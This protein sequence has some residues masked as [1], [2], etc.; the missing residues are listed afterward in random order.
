[1]LGFVFV[2]FLF[3]FCLFVFAKEQPQFGEGLW[4]RGV[5]KWWDKWVKVESW[6]LVDSLCPAWD[7]FLELSVDSFWPYSLLQAALSAWDSS[8]LLSQDKKKF[9]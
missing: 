5:W 2:L 4:E 1:L 7:G 8:L 6:I 3:V 9:F